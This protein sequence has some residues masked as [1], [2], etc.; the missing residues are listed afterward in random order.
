MK[1]TSVENQVPPPIP[2]PT[3]ESGV[4]AT[5]DVT[6]VIVGGYSIGGSPVTLH[7]TKD[8]RVVDD[9]MDE[10]QLLYDTGW[11]ST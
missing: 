9:V 4:T 3:V 6:L 8:K 1:E 10:F 2:H 11:I 7:Q 5:E